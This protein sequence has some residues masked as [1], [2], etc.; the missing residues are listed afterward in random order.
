MLRFPELKRPTSPLIPFAFAAL[1]LAVRGQSLSA[2]TEAAPLGLLRPAPGEIVRGTLVLEWERLSPKAVFLDHA[3]GAY[4]VP[5][6]QT[7]ARTPSNTQRLEIPARA[8]VPG[9]YTVRFALGGGDEKSSA[10]FRLDP[11]RQ[12]LLLGPRGG[13]APS[14]AQRN[15]ESRLTDLLDRLSRETRWG[16]LNATGLWGRF[17]GEKQVR[18]SLQRLAKSDLALVVVELTP[19]PGSPLRFRISEPEASEPIELPVSEFQSIADRTFFL[20]TPPVEAAAPLDAAELSARCSEAGLKHLI[21]QKADRVPAL[22]GE[23][24]TQRRGLLSPQRPWLDV[25]DLARFLAPIA[26]GPGPGDLGPCPLRPWHWR[27][28]TSVTNVDTRAIITEVTNEASRSRTTRNIVVYE[29]ITAGA[30]RKVQSGLEWTTNIV[31]TE[32][33]WEEMTP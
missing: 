25:D 17:T 10:A 24:F 26:A 27:P 18:G 5:V 19:S 14:E 20:F 6:A 22:I 21:L 2:P 30:V 3:S 31:T 7:L 32:G 8:F 12:V 23:F 29:S 9:D 13:S 16:L 28:A 11:L 4:S 33:R 1:V 15:R